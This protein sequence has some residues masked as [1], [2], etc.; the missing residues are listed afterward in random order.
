MTTHNSYSIDRQRRRLSNILGT[1]IVI[2]VVTAF[3]APV[4]FEL[5]PSGLLQAICWAGW[6]IGL[7]GVIWVLV[8]GRRLR[9]MSGAA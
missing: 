7:L 1:S 3:L 8:A 2:W 4:A 5:S 6:A 9:R